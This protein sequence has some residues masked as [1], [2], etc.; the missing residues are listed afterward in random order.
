MLRDDSGPPESRLLHSPQKA[1]PVPSLDQAHQRVRRG[2]HYFVVFPGPWPVR[3]R[4]H[5]PVPSTSRSG[6]TTSP[7]PCYPGSRVDQRLRAGLRCRRGDL[8]AGF[9]RPIPYR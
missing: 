4:R 5:E 6:A 7:S 1:P 3:L 8:N 9:S 2:D